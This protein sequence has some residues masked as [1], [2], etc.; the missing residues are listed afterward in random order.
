M[1]RWRNAKKPKSK[2]S[3]RE[4]RRKKV[5]EEVMELDRNLLRKLRDDPLGSSKAA[6]DEAM[7]IYASERLAKR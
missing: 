4:T 3:K 2:S 7:E 1:K 6:M 5:T